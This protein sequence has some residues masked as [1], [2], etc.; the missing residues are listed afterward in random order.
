MGSW[1]VEKRLAP[2]G[3]KADKHPAN[4]Q[5][6]NI[7]PSNREDIR[8][9]KSAEVRRTQ[10][11]QVKQGVGG[12]QGRRGKTDNICEGRAST[13]VGHGPVHDGRDARPP[14]KLARARRSRPHRPS[15]SYFYRLVGGAV[16]VFGSI[17]FGFASLA[18]TNFQNS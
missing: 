8:R 6:M 5:L 16:F 17:H 10:T 4:L 9:G 15:N 7:L 3:R 14:L 18:L 13:P 11:G 2:A 1:A 12:S